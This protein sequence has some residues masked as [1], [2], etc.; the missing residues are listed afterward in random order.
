MRSLPVLLLSL[1]LSTG[2]L[3][4]QKKFDAELARAD[5]AEASLAAAGAELEACRAEAAGLSA[6]LA[7]AQARGDELDG[8]A[9]GLE[10]QNS[11]LH[12]QLTALETLMS[13]LSARS[14]KT[15]TQ[16]A[17]LE[18]LVA[19]LRSNTDAARTEAEAARARITELSEAARVE[20]EAAQ[21]RIAELEAEKD[22]L[23]EK[24]AA[25]DALVHSL[26]DEISAGQVQITE[27][28]G[29]LT[30]NLSNAILF[31]SGA[32]NLKDD[33]QTA[34]GKVAGVLA[35]V[36]DRE[37]RVEGHTDDDAVRAGASFADNWALSALRASGVVSLLVAEGVD[38]TN[39]AVVGY[40][41]HRPVVANDSAEGKAANRRTEIVL[42]PRLDGE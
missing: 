18:A 19:E 26:K 10:A 25:Y 20:A 35:K 15:K 29:K 11:A 38:P 40:G 28:S 16:K 30:V 39:I 24:T 33:G 4:G 34:L 5:S 2:C 6:D 31:D 8:L 22:A 17:D 42:V 27:L 12:E 32:T 3:V 1:S 14:R 7:Q 21:A 23:A 36:E 37:I 13:E 41:A 9:K